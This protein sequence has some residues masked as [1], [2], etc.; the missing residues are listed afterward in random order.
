MDKLYAI[1][2]VSDILVNSAQELFQPTDVSGFPADWEE[3]YDKLWFDSLL[4]QL[5]FLELY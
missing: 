4:T 5:E 3:Q 2:I 1:N